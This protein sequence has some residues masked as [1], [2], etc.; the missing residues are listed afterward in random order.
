[1]RPSL[2][3]VPL[4]LLATFVAACGKSPT[5][6]GD[7]LTQQ[8]SLALY[9]EVSLAISQALANVSYSAPPAGG[10]SATSTPFGGSMS[11]SG[12]CSAGGSVSVSGSYDGSYDTDVSNYAYNYTMTMDFAACQS[13]AQSGEFSIGG[14][15]NLVVTGSF[16]WTGTTYHY[17]YSEQ[18]GVSFQTSDGRSGS[19]QINYSATADYN[20]TTASVNLNG[21]I[22]GTDI[23]V[24]STG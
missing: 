14:D 15:P 1:M 4:A 12:A 13:N 3:A 5:E 23:S 10:P 22:C 7:Q 20:G 11:Y 19:C 18:G 21:N 9:A 16:S 17:T 8:E 24:A 6:G 2:R